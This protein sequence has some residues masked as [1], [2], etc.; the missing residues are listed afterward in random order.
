MILR[1]ALLCSIWLLPTALH[2]AP[3]AT[4]RAE[5]ELLLA[6]LQSSGCS[7]ERNGDWHD[8]TT[9]AQHLRR[10][11]EAM[12]ERGMVTT[13]ESFIER[14][15]SLSSASGKPYRVRC[16]EGA[17]VVS[18]AQWFDAAVKRRRAAAPPR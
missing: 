7:F 10:K 18:A 17:P 13:T 16:G 12:V 6:D 8:A 3:T 1:R 14:G 11:Y 9:A 4:A 2:A 5:I 15:A